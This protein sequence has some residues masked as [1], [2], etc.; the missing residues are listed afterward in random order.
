MES[1]TW[2]HSSLIQLEWLASVPWGIPHACL[3][4]LHLLVDC[5]VYQVFI[6]AVRDPNSVFTPAL[7]ALYLPSHCPTS[8]SLPST[9]NLPP[10]PPRP[11]RP[12]L[13]PLPPLPPPPPLPLPPP[14][15][16]P[17]LPPFSRQGYISFLFDCVS[18]KFLTLGAFEVMC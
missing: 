18:Q 9:N 2:T 7:Q 8:S 5:H 6:K 4:V 12:P 13:P 1:V 11:P 16:S 3:S 17:P 14:L 15:L 10:H